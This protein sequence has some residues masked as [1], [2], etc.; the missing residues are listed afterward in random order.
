MIK[1]TRDRILQT[2]LSQPRSTVQELANAVGINAISVR[3]H[4]SSLKADSLVVEEEERH[5]VGRPRLVYLLSEQGL[6]RFPTRYLR[7]TNRILTQLKDTLPEETVKSIFTDMAASLASEYAKKAEKLDMEDKLNMLQ[8]ILAEEGFSLEWFRNGDVYTIREISCPYI[9][10]GQSHP[11]VC[12]VDQAVISAVLSI[13]VE[14]VQCVLSGDGQCA[15][16]L[17]ANKIVTEKEA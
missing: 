2:L 6:E 4:L 3:H 17:P 8:D 16:S 7:L 11:E 5:G 10:V 9:H 13:P 14:K 15:F 12:L 1:S